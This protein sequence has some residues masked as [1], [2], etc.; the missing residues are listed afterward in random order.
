MAE[1]DRV[2]KNKLGV[3]FME[4]MEKLNAREALGKVGENQ[5]QIIDNFLRLIDDPYSRTNSAELAHIAKTLDR[6]LPLKQR[7]SHIIKSASASQS[8][9]HEGAQ[10]FRA[11]LIGNTLSGAARMALPVA[12]GA[13]GY[14][15][16][17]PQLALAGLALG[18]KAQTPRS[19]RAILEWAARRGGYKPIKQIGKAA[20]RTKKARAGVEILRKLVTG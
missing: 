2:L 17:G 20:F 1:V 4:T 5:G 9:Y 12:S 18:F 11:R 14:Y 19:A 6:N 13:A 15:T 3:K 8:L 7:I 10:L 16:G